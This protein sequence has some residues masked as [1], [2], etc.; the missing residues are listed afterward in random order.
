MTP[1]F[2]ELKVELADCTD[3]WKIVNK[4]CRA[5]ERAGLRYSA[6]MISLNDAMSS[7]NL[8]LTCS[9]WFDLDSASD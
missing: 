8:S 6:R 3:P 7:D 2:P 5:A 9:E 4:C 1:K